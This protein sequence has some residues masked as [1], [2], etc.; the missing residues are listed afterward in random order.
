MS[1]R[2]HVWEEPAAADVGATA[3]DLLARLPG[4]TLFRVGGADR[5]RTRA[6]V[7]LLH[8][9]EPSGTRAWHAWL[10]RGRRPAV[11]IVCILAAVDA[12]RHPPGF[13]FRMLP[14]RRDLNRCFLPPFD[15]DGDGALAEEILRALRQAHPEALLDVHNN[16]GHNPAYGVGNKIDRMRLALTSLFADRYMLSRVRLGSLTEATEDDFA[17]VTIECGMAGDPEADAVAAVG[18]ERFLE[19]DSLDPDPAAAAGVTVLETPLRVCLRRGASLAVA[20][21]AVAGADLTLAKDIDRHNFQTL[22]TGTVV[23]WLGSTAAWPIEAVDRGGH[24]HSR[25]MFVAEGGA[26][27]VREPLIPVMLTT[28]AEIAARDCL[29]YVARPLKGVG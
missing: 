29:F 19:T 4:P 18:L 20:D 23:G 9:N 27:L 24:D 17:G 1:A 28:N 26:L 13:A 5:R 10:R 15:R 7:T 16:T 3:E 21:A 11:N 6:I 12:A 22:D 2:L 25:E 14:E 8:G